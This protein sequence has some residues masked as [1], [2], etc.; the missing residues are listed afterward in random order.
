MESFPFQLICF[1]SSEVCFHHLLP[2]LVRNGN[3]GFQGIVLHLS[4]STAYLYR[5]YDN[6]LLPEYGRSA[7]PCQESGARAGLLL[8]QYHLTVRTAG[9][10]CVSGR[11]GG[12]A[13]Y[14]NGT[15]VKQ[16]RRSPQSIHGR[17][18]FNGVIFAGFERESLYS[19]SDKTDLT[20]Q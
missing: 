18:L 9:I 2:G 17:K 8:R 6:L 11:E 15:A 7:P 19:C 14:S 13:I 10:C 1:I 20:N 12:G 5:R 4:T 16:Q 3:I